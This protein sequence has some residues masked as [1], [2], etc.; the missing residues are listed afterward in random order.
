[1]N[2]ILFYAVVGLFALP[3]LWAIYHA[4]HHTFPTPQERVIWVC[5]GMFLPVLG[6]LAYLCFG[7]RR[8]TGKF[9]TKPGS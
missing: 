1:M 2:P 9:F 7:L 3:N 8:T 6:G 5:A 4:F